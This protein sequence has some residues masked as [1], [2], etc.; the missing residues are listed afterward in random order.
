MPTQPFYSL[1]WQQTFIKKSIISLMGEA[2]SATGIAKPVVEGGETAVGDFNGDGF[3]DVLL[4]YNQML[5]GTGASDGPTLGRMSLLLGRGDGTFANGNALLPDN[6]VFDALIRKVRVGDFNGDGVD[7]VVMAINREDGRDATNGQNI[8]LQQVALMSGGGKLNALALGLTTWGHGLAAGDLNGDGLQDFIISGFTND[9]DGA[10]AR[11]YVQL[12][13]GTLSEVTLANL[14]GQSLAI[15]DFDADGI[16]ELVDYYTEYDA[17]GPTKT[18]L[19][20]ITLNPDGSF[21]S[22]SFPGEPGSYR[23]EMGLTWS[24]P[25]LLGVRTGTDGQEFVDQGLHDMR[26]GDVN[27]DGLP[28]IVAVRAASAMLYENDVLVSWGQNRTHFEFYTMSA[29]QMVEMD[30]K[31][32]G[33]QFAGYDMLHYQLLDWNGDGH[34]D[35]F[36]TWPENQPGQ[37]SDLARIFLNDGTG[38][39]TRFNQ[40]LLPQ[41]TDGFWDRATPIDA[42]GDGIMD[43]LVSPNGFDS[44]RDLWSVSSEY[45]YLGNRQIYSGPKYSNPALKGAPG[46]NESYYLHMNP[47]VKRLVN[48]GTF[49]SGLDHFLQIGRDEGR[50]AFAP[51]TKVYGSANPDQIY[52]REGNE[53][54][55]GLSGADQIWGGLGADTLVGGSGGDIFRFESILESPGKGEPHD[56]ITDFGLGSDLIDL[57]AIDANVLRS[58]NNAFKFHVEQI[59]QLSGI[60]GELI[61]FV[62]GSGTS[63]V[64][65][66][67]GDVDGDKVADFR[68]DLLGSH[69][70]VGAD[71]LV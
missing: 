5:D 30:C 16:T 20:M 58:G 37:G 19:R 18:G 64:T 6:G 23:Y 65:V 14:S 31:I 1:A 71:F 4:S 33:W 62:S 12:A 42:N 45:L 51:G 29:G 40:R 50:L 60:A 59:A 13:N 54:A 35:L 57:R 24:G 25:G 46:F 63:A 26:V 69:S 11:A 39:F 8:A 66:I 70:L 43:L 2:T 61:W 68:L 3:A 21:Q 38:Q 7:D 32:L 28:D 22:I 49:G 52:L 53:T 10:Q 67:K 48:G 44:S 56:T 47:D 9:T 17:S 34:L 41:G 55:F 36:V 15:A 27:G